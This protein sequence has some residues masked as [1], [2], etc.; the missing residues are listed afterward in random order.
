MLPLIRLAFRLLRFFI[1]FFNSGLQRSLVTYRLMFSGL[2][3]RLTTFSISFSPRVIPLS[4]YWFSLNSLWIFCPYV[5]VCVI[6]R[7]C[8]C[9][10]ARRL[11][12][13]VRETRYYQC[14]SVVKRERLKWYPEL[15]HQTPGASWV[16]AH[17]STARTKG[18]MVKRMEIVEERDR[19]SRR[20]ASSLGSAAN[21]VWGLR[22]WGLCQSGSGGKVAPLRKRAESE[23][24][25]DA[26]ECVG[27]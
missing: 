10:C 22:L 17:R 19:W 5:C 26:R 20:K 6:I 11:H 1:Y 7:V 18:A 13:C 2:V 8:I 12:A 9:A 16:M 27:H 25:R 24:E 21:S 14:G 15:R 23:W 4:Q 3:W